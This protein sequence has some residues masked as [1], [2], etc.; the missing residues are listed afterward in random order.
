M[1]WQ[2]NV[3][4]CVHYIP[5]AISLHE[6][7]QILLSATL[8]WQGQALLHDQACYGGPW[9]WL[10]FPGGMDSWMVADMDC[11]VCRSNESSIL[12][13]LYSSDMFCIDMSLMGPIEPPST[14]GSID[15]FH[16]EF[17][18]LDLHMIPNLNGLTCINVVCRLLLKTGP[19]FQWRPN[20]FEGATL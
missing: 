10:M 18:F 8:S 17:V 15:D 6:L 13:S 11:F 9:A 3:G 2:G 14:F 7:R 12:V 1:L 19:N 16:L 4:G 5:G 20:A